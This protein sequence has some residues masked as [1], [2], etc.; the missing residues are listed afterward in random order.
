MFQQQ[1]FDKKPILV[2]GTSKLKLFPEILQFLSNKIEKIYLVQAKGP[3]KT[4]V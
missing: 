1:K 2:Y 4:D 3:K